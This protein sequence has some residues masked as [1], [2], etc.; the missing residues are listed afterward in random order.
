MSI[1][2][3]S[4]AHIEYNSE[5]GDYLCVTLLGQ[6]DI[7]FA[8]HRSGRTDPLFW[9]LTR[10]KESEVFGEMLAEGSMEPVRPYNYYTDDPS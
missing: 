4:G 2:P 6:A 5:M 7:R 1:S 10:L 3:F 8:A 9:T